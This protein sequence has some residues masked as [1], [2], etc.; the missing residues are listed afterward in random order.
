[1]ALGDR[2]RQRRIEL[3]MT[4]EDVAKAVGVGKGT[5]SKW[6]TGDIEHMR[7]D[8]IVLLAEALR[9]SPL[10]IIGLEDS[11]KYDYVNVPVYGTIPAGVPLESLT[12]IKGEVDIPVE[13]TNGGKKYVGL[14]VKGDSMYPKYL[15]KDI[16]I[17]KL[18]PDCENGQDCACYVNG[19]DV[20]LKKVCKSDSEIILTPLNPNY[21]PKTYKGDEVKILGVVKEIRRRV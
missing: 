4:L 10:W 14:E 17:I 9:V 7:R 12:D 13:W 20:T 6:E 11:E 19:Y 16:V 5:V 1:M 3:D 21:P 15:E 2:I 8:K 18:Q